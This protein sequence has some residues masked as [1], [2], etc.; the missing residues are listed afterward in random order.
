[1][2][3]ELKPCPFCGAEA[4]LFVDH[5]VRV[6]CPK[7]GASSQCLVDRMIAKGPTG[8]ATKRVIESW[9]KRVFDEKCLSN[10]SERGGT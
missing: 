2:F 1:M 5:G 6:M 10:I 9:N 7:C 3:D 4:Y 8:N